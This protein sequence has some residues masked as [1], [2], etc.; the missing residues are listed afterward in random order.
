[1]KI[2]ILAN[3]DVGL[4]KFRRE[5]ILE[6][7]KEHTV[8]ISLPNGE[9]IDPL[10]NDGCTFID[11]PVDRRGMNPIKDIKLYRRYISMLS[12]IQPDLVVTYTIKPNIYGGMACRSKGITYAANITGL[13]T[14]FEKDEL[15]K[16]LV[17]FMYKKALKK[18]KVVFFENSYN[19][20]LFIDEKIIS[21]E[22]SHLLNGA[23]VNLDVY[24]YQEYPH[25][26]RFRFLFIG[27]VMKEKGIEELFSAM[28]KLIDNGCNC[29][30]DVVGPLE[31]NYREIIDK[32][33]ADGWLY[34][35]GYQKDVIPFI[36]GCDCFVLP[37]YHE[38]MANTNLECAASGRP[39]IT[40]NIPGCREAVIDLESGFICEPRDVESLYS[41]MIEI[42]QMPNRA[43]MGKKGRA[44]MEKAYDKRGVIA[45]TK[46]RL[47]DEV[48]V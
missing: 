27:R 21:Q 48:A 46:S 13:G 29:C 43:E 28:E 2:L 41:K 30:L 19:Q 32:N 47:F 14:A 36:K 31:E 5:L 23:G 12:D 1:M 25:N 45:E 38:G 35:H 11:T 34:Y 33:E 7:L 37:S 24:S 15:V 22:Q 17:K 6:L 39:I 4:F 40:S 3:N 16:H 8:Y 18:A 26:D 10:V 20:K 44:Y 42:Y 9:L